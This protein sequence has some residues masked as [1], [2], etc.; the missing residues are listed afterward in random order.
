MEP[1][2]ACCWLIP[3]AVTISGLQAYLVLHLG[4]IY[5]IG[6]GESLKGYIVE[7][8]HIPFLAL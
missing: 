2:D 8:S 7:G 1:H 3:M 5:I 4:P 6:T